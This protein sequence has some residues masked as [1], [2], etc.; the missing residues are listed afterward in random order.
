M[1]TE[2]QTTR[3]DAT[4]KNLIV[5]MRAQKTV[6]DMFARI[7]FSPLSKDDV[8]SLAHAG[9]SEAAKGNEGSLYDA[10]RRMGDSLQ[11]DAEEL[12]LTLNID[13]TATFYGISQYEGKVATPYES[14]FSSEEGLLYGKPRKEVF[15]ELKSETLRLRDGIDLPEDHLSFELL[16][17]GT[18]CERA[19]IALEKKDCSTAIAYLEKQQ[20]FVTEH[21][22]NWIDDLASLAES[23]L[24][25]PFYNETLTAIKAFAV[26][27]VEQ[28]PAV[29][30][31]VRN[32]DPIEGD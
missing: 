7:L 11:G 18:L 30:S 1:E 14:V 15:E 27:C 21:I 29:I 19:A 17:L 28:L 23:L 20:R 2:V 32:L 12:R 3:E 26:G 8:E 10:L 22:L 16:F 6:A 25:H 5:E 31:I 4:V 13:Y 9:F 24:K